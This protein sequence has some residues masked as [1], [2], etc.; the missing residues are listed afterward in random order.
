MHGTPLEHVSGT[1]GS[2]RG[3][4][5]KI[6]RQH[7]CPYYRKSWMTKIATPIRCARH[8]RNSNPYSVEFK[9]MKQRLVIL[10]ATSCT[11]RLA[12]SSHRITSPVNRVPF[13]WPGADGLEIS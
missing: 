3:E 7:L 9:N 5:F 13:I 6:F 4:T 8:F 12:P 11:S 10:C 2:R 1:L